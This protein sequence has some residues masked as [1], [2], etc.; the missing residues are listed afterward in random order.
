MWHIGRD[1]KGRVQA[2]AADR[3]HAFQLESQKSLVLRTV[4]DKV[5]ENS[6]SL[7]KLCLQSTRENRGA[8][9]EHVVALL[10]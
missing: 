1:C 6:L 5:C 4:Y 9:Y 3:N 8:T 7:L 10:A 2:I